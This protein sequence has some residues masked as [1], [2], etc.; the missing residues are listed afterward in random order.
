MITLLLK[1][2]LILKIIE[3]IHGIEDCRRSKYCSGKY[4]LSKLETDLV[5]RAAVHV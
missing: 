1:G 4:A 3:G 2:V 5:L